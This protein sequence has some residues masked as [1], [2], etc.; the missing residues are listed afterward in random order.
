MAEDSGSSPKILAEENK[1]L[2]RA[3]EELS[4]L[5]EIASAISST[6]S[7]DKIVELVVQKCVKHLK[8]EQT[9]VMLLDEQRTENPFQTMIRRA[10]HS[11]IDVPYHLNVHLTGWMLKNK[12]PLMI[13]DLAHD[14]RFTAIAKGFEHIR[15]LLSVPLF[16]KGRMIGLVT[17]FNKKTAEGFNAE[18]DR[19]L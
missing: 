14:E 3:V 2:R 16:L 12:K 8:V 11:K 15:S 1:K 4:I 5:N 6:M 17:C 13:N 7:L 10:D 18:D 9:A 19:L